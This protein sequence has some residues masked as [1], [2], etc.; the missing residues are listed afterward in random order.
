MSNG[1]IGTFEEFAVSEYGT[2]LN[3]NGL[4]KSLEH[5]NH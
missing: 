1:E 2:L 5:L 3:Y 4:K